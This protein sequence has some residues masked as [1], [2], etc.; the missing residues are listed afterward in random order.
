MILNNFYLKHF[1]ESSSHFSVHYNISKITIFDYSIAKLRLYYE[2]VYSQ[3]VYHIFML[4][5]HTTIL[6]E[7]KVCTNIANS[8]I[9][10]SGILET[11]LHHC[12][13]LLD[14]LCWHYVNYVFQIVFQMDPSAVGYTS[15]TILKIFFSLKEEIRVSN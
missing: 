14:C 2:V 8:F 12:S 15:S 9:S 13:F 4:H 3:H 6:L 5:V 10:S 11:W 7:E 1:S